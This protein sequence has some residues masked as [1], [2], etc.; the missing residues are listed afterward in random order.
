MDWTHLQAGLS[1]PDNDKR[2]HALALL[3]QELEGQALSDPDSLATTLRASVKSNNAHVANAALACLPP[4]FTAIVP[5]PDSASPP[6]TSAA[7]QAHSLKHAVQLLLPFDKL[8]DAKVNT[9]QLAREGIVSAAKACMR[10]G[11]EAGVGVKD[12]E[13]AWQTLEKGVQDLGFRSKSAKAREQALHFLEAIRCPALDS[14]TPLPSLSPYTPLLLPL[15]S[16]SD[17]TVRSLALSTTIAVFSHPSVSSAAKSDLKKQMVKLDVSKKVQDQVLAAVLGGGAPPSSLE[18]SPSQASLS[19]AGSSSRAGSSQLPPP[20]PLVAPDGPAR[21]TRSQAASSSTAAHTPSL[22]S[23][24][25]A[26]AFPSDPSAVHTPS[27]ADLSPVYV[28]S[29]RDLRAEFDKM[30]PGFE[31]KETEHNWQA[32]DRSVA[33][34]RGMLLGGV[35]GGEL[36]GAFVKAVKEVAEPICRVSASLRTTLALSALSL[37]NELSTSLPP[38]QVDLFLDPFL[39]HLLSMAGQTKK[40]V[41]FASQSTVTSL[42][43]HSTYHLRSLQLV[44]ALL[45]DK[46]VSARQFGAQHLITFLTVHGAASYGAIDASGGADELEQAVKRALADPNAGVR[47]TGRKA[48]WALEAA[49][50][51]DR[52]E[53]ILSGLDA[54]GK[55]GV[56]KAR[57]A[58]GGANGAAKPVSAAAAAAPAARTTRAAAGAAGGA[59]KPSVR[60]QMMAMRRQK[61]QEEAAGVVQPADE[62]LPEG[63]GEAEK[64]VATPPRRE[65]SSFSPAPPSTGSTARGMLSPPAVGSPRRSPASASRPLPMGDDQVSDDELAVDATPA[66]NGED[67]SLMHSPSPFRLKSPLPSASPSTRSPVQ[68]PSRLPSSAH[69]PRTPASAPHARP[70]YTPM[71]SAPSQ[72]S[73]ASSASTSRSTADLAGSTRS[74]RAK[75]RASLLPDPVVDDALRDQAMQ[76][77]QAAERLLELAED[78]AALDASSNGEQRSA[79]PKPARTVSS[80]A[81]LVMQTPAMNP[82][83]RRLAAMGGGKTFEDSPDAKDGMGGGRGSWWLRKG[84]SLPPP[85][86][87]APD[88]S[89]R[90]AEIASLISS[91]QSLSIDAPSLRKLS[92]LSKERPVREVEDDEDEEDGPASPSKNGA[93]G[94]AAGEAG[95]TTT[96]RFWQ[97]ERRFEKVYEGLK[98]FLLQQPGGAETGLTRD[99][100]LILLKDLV[101]NQFPLFA[102]VE[103]ELFSLIFRLREDPSRTSIAATESIATLFTS[104][105]EPIYGLGALTPSLRAYLAT[106]AQPSSADGAPQHSEPIARS[107]A[108]GLKL[109]GSLFEGLPQEILEDVLPSSKELIKRALNDSSSGDLR[110]SAI[111]ALVSAQSVLRD[112]QR[113]V[114]LVDGLARDQANLLSYYAAKR[115]V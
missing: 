28:P 36:Q 54:A 99:H 41:A 108:L 81:A 18:R 100:A 98:A 105:L 69:A 1:H 27:S 42:L 46:T 15:L 113:L 20:V 44:T 79:T 9:R 110:R 43:Q 72:T 14:A 111:F 63:D 52:A 75:K 33:T 51:P 102:G 101:D 84:E 13:G 65:R 35:V 107:F 11:A 112:E 58:P 115:G 61:Q 78:E 6:P 97:D 89:T 25:P 114:E 53:R 83:R 60:E 37:I 66:A 31:G 80:A 8:G 106:S 32:R 57:P 68:T 39:P 24:L 49:G 87:L 109:M 17:S 70:T 86:P 55:K 73:L 22:L 10:L 94:H 5:P 74:P 16:D 91:L 47:E 95:S 50:W 21:R 103:A 34:I 90:S 45:A 29:E 104:R 4:F 85:P 82:A 38:P 48:Y 26:A 77:E 64:A 93:N 7:S 19:S 62:L 56:E 71:R 59:K 88:S 2:I 67:N 76:A 12:K 23:S 30:R 96:A 3:R 92:A 40:I